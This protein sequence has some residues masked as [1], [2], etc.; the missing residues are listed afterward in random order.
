MNGETKTLKEWSQIVNIDPAT[1]RW[2]HLQGWSDE[3][4]L[5]EENMKS[6]KTYDQWIAERRSGIGA[7]ESSAVLG[8]NPYCS[9]VELWLQ[10]TGRVGSGG[11][12]G[13]ALRQ[14][15]S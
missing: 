3:E 9:N 7:S 14:V 13:Q 10:K 2:R 5:G 8:L 1:L 12:R 11:H 15:W 6:I 4:T